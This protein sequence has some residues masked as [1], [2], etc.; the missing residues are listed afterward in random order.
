MKQAYVLVGFVGAAVV[1]GACSDDDDSNQRVEPEVCAV[2]GGSGSGGTPGLDAG[3]DSEADGGAAPALDRELMQLGALSP[4]GS[5]PEDPTN[6]FADDAHAQALGQRLFFDKKF[7]GSLIVASDLG[8]VGEAGKISCASCHSGP[9]LDDV[10]SV[11][12]NVSLGTNFHTRNSPPLVNSSYYAW[13]NWGGRFST[14]WELP[15]AVAENSITMNGNRLS[16]AHRL[17]EVY[18]TEYEAVFGPLDAEIGTNSTRFPAAGK[19]KPAPT[20][21]N[22]NPADGPWEGMVL[23]DQQIINRILVNYSKALAAYTR[24]LVSSNSKFDRWIAG[25]DAALTAAE[26]R[27]ARLFVGK[28]KCV[29][30][31][32]GPHFS[33]SGFHNLGV[34]QTGDHVPVSD[35]G[36][37]KD[38]PPLLGSVFNSSGAYSDTPHTGLLNGLVNPMPDETKGQFRTPTLRNVELTAPYMHSGQFTTLEAVIDFYNAAGGSPLSGAKSPLLTPLNLSAQEKA[39]LIAFM[40]ALTSEALPAAL[41]ADT[42]KP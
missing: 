11:P 5:V 30:C 1:V 17:F 41:V 24:L 16:I 34:P 20:P 14:Q 4:L 9:A 27:G 40:K 3:R 37:F 39:D 6:A 18:R 19:P 12:K 31:H 28:A 10:R 7:S 33:D 25:E 23:A 35:D 21:T 29:S 42:S 26:Q 36:R 15:L 32:S 8:S 2:D 38:V 13:T 22:P